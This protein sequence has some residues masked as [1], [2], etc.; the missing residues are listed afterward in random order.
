MNKNP[1]TQNKFIQ[2]NLS[3]PYYSNSK[4]LLKKKNIYIP[5]ENIRYS[6]QEYNDFQKDIPAHKIHRGNCI[7]PI[8]NLSAYENAEI[9]STITSQLLSKKYQNILQKDKNI[10]NYLYSENKELKKDIE[11]Q[12]LKLKE[13][14]TKII[15]NSLSLAKNIY[16]IENMSVDNR[17]IKKKNSN[18]NIKLKNVKQKNIEFLD[19]IGINIVPLNDKNNNIYINIDKTW[20]YINKISK[21]KNNI[22][23]VLRYKIL[24]NLLVLT[25]KKKNKIIKS[26]NSKK[27]EC[28]KNYKTINFEEQND[29]KKNDIKIEIIPIKKR[30]MIPFNNNRQKMIQIINRS[31]NFSSSVDK[32][33]LQ[34]KPKS[35]I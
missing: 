35:D 9:Q 13:D 29:K 2:Y 4:F 25:G 15:K 5:K 31:Y 19:S 30:T 32:N 23:D 10:K 3:I 14:L 21:G 7:T 12:K 17:H 11:L 27:S 26:S 1:I 8:K 6:K 18:E 20:N 28:K 34:Q 33:E 24:N 16:K 22:D